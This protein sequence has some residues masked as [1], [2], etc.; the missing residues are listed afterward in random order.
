MKVQRSAPSCWARATGTSDGRRAPSTLLLPCGAAT[1]DR[2]HDWARERQAAFSKHQVKH[3]NKKVDLDKCL[4]SLVVLS[5]KFISQL[6]YCSSTEGL[7]LMLSQESHQ[8][9]PKLPRHPL[10]VWLRG[11]KEPCRG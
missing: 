7:K 6:C 5:I 3:M 9:D 10:L 8:A 11:N 1:R 4:M 2:R